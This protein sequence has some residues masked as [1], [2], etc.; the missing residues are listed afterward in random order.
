MRTQD[1]ERLEADAR[2]TARAAK[3]L[4]DSVETISDAGFDPTESDSVQAKQ[5]EL[6]SEFGQLVVDVAAA[7]DRFDTV[8]A[9]RPEWSPGHDAV[10]LEYDDET[11]T[12]A[13]SYHGDDD[14]TLAVEIDGEPDSDLTL[15]SGD[16]ETVPVTDA[17]QLSVSW[18]ASDVADRVEL[19]PWDTITDV[20]LSVEGDDL[21]DA[22]FQGDTRELSKSIRTTATEPEV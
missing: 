21:P 22:R 3:Q 12:V 18:Q 7:T 17:E 8:R 19:T 15:A 5:H 9:N 16:T 4:I 14:I 11:E 20:Q 1:I 6:A 10:S 13:I 2:R